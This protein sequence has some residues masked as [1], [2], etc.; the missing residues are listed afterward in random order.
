MDSSIL[1]WLQKCA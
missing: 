1:Q